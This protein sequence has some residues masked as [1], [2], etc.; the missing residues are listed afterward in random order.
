MMSARN[1]RKILV[2]VSVLA[3]FSI[4]EAYCADGLFDGGLYMFGQAIQREFQ[5]R[6]QKEIDDA[7]IQEYLINGEPVSPFAFSSPSLSD[8]FMGEEIP[9]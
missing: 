5:K 2:S 3:G 7:D 4:G 6:N 9:D 1:L 8:E